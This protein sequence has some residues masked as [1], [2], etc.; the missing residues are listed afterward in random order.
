MLPACHEELHAP[1]K[2]FVS[3][4]HKGMKRLAQLWEF[5]AEETKKAC[6][7]RWIQTS[8]TEMR[9]NATRAEK[10]RNAFAKPFDPPTKIM[11]VHCE[12]NYCEVHYCEITRAFGYLIG[13]DPILSLSG[14]RATQR[15]TMN[16]P[17]EYYHCMIYKIGIARA[18]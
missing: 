6:R 14:R 4:H 18:L 8:S 1:G 15:L 16:I 2:R 3:S 12:S 5:N 17:V 13:S 7:E 9:T 11:T 10:T